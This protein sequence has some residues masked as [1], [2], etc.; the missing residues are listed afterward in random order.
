MKK[1]ICANIMA[2]FLG[3]SLCAMV[4][5]STSQL[6]QELTTL[7]NRLEVLNNEL[8]AVP[9]VVQPEPVAPSPEVQPGPFATHGLLIFLDDTEKNREFGAVSNGLVTAL[10]QEAGPIV[11]S[12]S[13]IANVRNINPNDPQNLF[14]RYT[15]I[16]NKSELTAEDARE[17]NDI[18]LSVISFNV[19]TAQQK[20]VI[21]KI[22]DSLYLLL[23]KKYL[24]AKGISEKSLEPFMATEIT[25]T[26]QALGL[27]VNHM[28]T[29][30]LTDIKKPLPEKEYASYFITALPDIFVTN[31]EYPAA[32]KTA[33]P[34]WAIYIEGHGTLGDSI[35]GLDFEQFQKFLAFLDQKVTTKLLF[36]SS[37]YAAG[38]NVVLAY[39]D[40]EKNIDRTYSFVI[41]TDSVPDKVVP[42]PSVL[43]YMGKGRLEV[44][45]DRQYDDFLHQVTTSDIIDYR[46][47]VDP[48]I[49]KS[50]LL[51]SL[52]QIKFPGLPWFS[53]I[54][55]DKVVSIGSVLAK[56]RTEPLEIAKFF[57]RKGK[58]AEP[59]G[60]LLYAKDIPFELVID[61]KTMPV[62]IS[63]LPGSVTHYIKKVSFQNSY[64]IDQN[65]LSWSEFYKGYILGA[66]KT[67]II[68][69]I[70][71]MFS[72]LMKSSLQ[73]DKGTFFKVV[74]DIFRE[75]VLIFFTYN[76]KVYK[77][78]S[79]TQ[80][81]LYFVLADE[82]E[83]KGYNQILA[84][85][86]KSLKKTIEDIDI[87]DIEKKSVRE[88]LTPENIA[89]IK[90][91]QEKR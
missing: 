14:K 45:T 44:K 50:E 2:I 69:E 65:F 82:A 25:S 74:L 1:I 36:I 20:W 37:C 40:I 91:A 56:T 71:G 28:Q 10:L 31:G 81:R 11:A 23:P 30:Q 33:I 68:G 64:S 87:E 7:T 5:P 66:N 76:E 48:L 52:P 60:I 90:A 75:K 54:D 21:K 53:V 26:E 47:L 78:V 18:M 67:F 35:I 49:T 62:I 9:V 61:T 27:K 34:R 6:T 72:D 55:T 58:L 39:N 4:P 8:K 15:T 32:N 80:T 70:T 59:F 13:V 88:Q 63:M 79:P 43:V 85:Y 29:V 38:L 22:N 51:A 16:I 24:Q 86:A 19:T 77:A 73:G 17:K 89:K 3:T 42:G 84:E 41:I 57:K 83:K 12:A 46:K